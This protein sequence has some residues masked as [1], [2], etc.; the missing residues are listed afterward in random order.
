M[1][2][3][4]KSFMNQYMP[5]AEAT[6]YNEPIKLPAIARGGTRGGMNLATLSQPDTPWSGAGGMTPETI[7]DFGIN[8]QNPVPSAEQTGMISHETAQTANEIAGIVTSVPQ[9]GPDVQDLISWAFKPTVIGKLGKA[10][11]KPEHIQKAV[12]FMLGIPD[13]PTMQGE[14]PP[15]GE[16]TTGLALNAQNLGPP[17]PSDLTGSVAAG[18]GSAGKG[19]MAPPDSSNPSVGDFGW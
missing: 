4:L 15:S 8:T 11:F 13:Q 17:T 3:S 10:L 14:V 18:A 6:N 2:Y 12:N 7:S 5:Q 9:K 16:E 1:A 19:G